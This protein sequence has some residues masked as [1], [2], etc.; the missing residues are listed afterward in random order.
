MDL[1][2]SL[3]ELSWIPRP[4]ILALRRLAL[5]TVGDLL[6]HYPRRH[7]DRREFRGFPREETIVPVCLCGEVAKTRLMRFGGRKIFEAVLEESGAHALS[8]PLTCRWFNL[9]YIQKMIATGQRLVVFGRVKRKGPRLLIDHPEFE[10]IEDDEE[11][12]IHFRRITPI[13]PATEGLS[14]RVLRGLIFRLLEQVEIASADVPL[15]ASL[16][17]GEDENALRKIHFPESD[18]QL[19]KVRDHL[20]LGEFFRMQMQ[21][22]A[23]RAENS[24]RVGCRH[25][26]RGL[27][28]EQFI[29]ALPF[30]FTS[31][32]QRVFN[33]VKHDLQVASPMNRLLQGDVGSGKTVVAIA[34]MLLAVESGSQAALMAPTQ[35]LAE[36]HYAVLRNWLDPLGIRIALRTGARQEDNAPLPLFARAESESLGSAKQDSAKNVLTTRAVHASAS[37]GSGSARVSRVGDGVMPSQTFPQTDETPEARYSRR[38]LPHFEKPWAIYAVTIGTKK[39]RC[40]SPKART[41]ALDTLRYFHNKRY[42]L[43]AAC[44]M[45]DHVH[46]LIQPWPK[47]NDDAGN[48]V[49]WSLKKLLHSIK[50]YSAHAINKA[51]RERGGVWEKERFDRYIRS[52]PDLI[53]K[54]EYILR[55]PWDSGVVKPGEDYPWVWTHDDE[56]RVKSPFPRDAETNTRDECATRK[57]EDKNAPQIIIGTHALLYESVNFTNLGLAVIDE[58]HKFGVAQRAKLTS[59]EPAPDVLVMT[60]TPIPR[61]LTMTIYGDLEISTI[62]EMPRNRGKVVT[63][64][65]DESKLGE[66]LMFL[67][68]KLEAGRQLYVIYPL[69]DESER[70]DAKAAA[71]EYELWKE[72]LHPFRCDLL[73]GRIPS[74]EKQEI[75]E[76][77]RSGETSALISTTVLEVGVDIPNASV[78]LIENAER[79]GL[80]QLHQLR[81]RIGRGEHKSYCILLTSA[82][83]KE[84][85]AKLAVLERTRD[86]FEVAEAD[87]ELRGPGDLLGTAQSGLPALKIGNLKTD[88]HLMRRARAAAVSILERDPRLELPENQRFRRLIVEQQGRTFSNVS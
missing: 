77:F 13:Y 20:V 67:R 10:V 81:G 49:F 28:A 33:E 35:I 43:F 6:T 4:R 37:V 54:F 62:E 32:Q 27:L 34:A 80:A 21:I 52:R 22:V 31:A 15:P 63:A 8:Q 7:E 51:E 75:M 68:T 5:Q 66:V 57:E 83:A 55:N 46:F 76:R 9:H 26:S 16:S 64:V 88:A 1:D 45:P 47:E 82:Q 2:T 38:R 84:A 24:A 18:Q 30:A 86:G 50:S 17:N 14:Q 40:F 53:E 74:S 72:R 36:Q 42:E 78:M 60:A 58:Q 25:Q 48:V 12:L 65:R 69:I 71:A 3:E 87:W 39:R 19:H 11:I 79:F 59:R 70:L 44:V 85:S 23:A 73:H 29:A 56:Y 41:I 61:T